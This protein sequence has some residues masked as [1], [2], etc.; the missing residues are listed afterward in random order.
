MTQRF[1]GFEKIHLD[2][3]ENRQ[4][5]IKKVETKCITLMGIFS[6]EDD[7]TKMIKLNFSLVFFFDKIISIQ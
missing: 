3:A 6:F 5:F 4:I 1:R 2:V 7:K